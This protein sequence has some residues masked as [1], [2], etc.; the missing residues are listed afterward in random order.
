MPT[1]SH[2]SAPLKLTYTIVW[3][4]AA[5][6]RMAAWPPILEALGRALCHEAD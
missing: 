4:M 5:I 6:D 3:A 1:F 2:T